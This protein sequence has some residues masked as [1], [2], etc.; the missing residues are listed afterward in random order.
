MTAF[1]TPSLFS[2]KRANLCLEEDCEAI[3]FRHCCISFDKVTGV[4]ELLN[5][6]EYGVTVNEILYGCH[7]G[8]V[9]RCP[10][11]SPQSSLHGWEGPCQLANGAN[12]RIGCH[13]F[14][15]ETNPDFMLSPDS[16]VAVDRACQSKRN[17]LDFMT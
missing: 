9:V 15:F 10:R 12:I 2:D 1:L 17:S 13:S 14:S 7:S 6:S 5:Y 16:C 8:S 4:H 11:C 3:S